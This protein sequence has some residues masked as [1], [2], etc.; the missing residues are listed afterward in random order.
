MSCCSK[1]QSTKIP[2]VYSNDILL[3]KKYQRK[4]FV[5][6]KDFTTKR[7]NKFICS[8]DSKQKRTLQRSLFR[9]HNLPKRKAEVITIKKIPIDMTKCCICGF[10]TTIDHHHFGFNQLLPLCP[11]HHTMIHRHHL[12]LIIEENSSYVTT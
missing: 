7:P 2:Q 3:P 1:N 4:C 5:C 6:G 12:K 8:F 11:N 10:D 9:Y